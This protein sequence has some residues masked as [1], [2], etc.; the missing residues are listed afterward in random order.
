MRQLLSRPVLTLA[1]GLLALTAAMLPIGWRL[2]QD[3]GLLALFRLRGPIAPP[4]AVAVLR[5]D[6]RTLGRFHDLP[7]AMA[8][9]PEPL[10]GCAVLGSLDRLRQTTTLD[11]IP[12]AAY[13][14]AVTRLT[15]LG[16]AVIGF[17][18]TFRDDP[19]RNAGSEILAQAIARHG[20]TVVLT[21]ARR[22]WLP[23]QA[24]LLQPE[25]YFQALHPEIA[26]AAA[27]IA[28]FQLPL[29][30][31][32]F[33]QFWNVHP[34]APDAVQLPVRMLQLWRGK[35]EPPARPEHHLGFFG[36]AGTIPNLALGD[37]LTG[38]EGGTAPVGGWAGSAVLIGL[39]EPGV[40]LAP[41]SFVTVFG[42]ARGIDLSGVE[43]AATAF[44]NLRDGTE[45]RLPPEGLRLSIILLLACGLTATALRGNIVH[46]TLI[47][48]ALAGSWA[49][50]ALLAFQQAYWWLPTAV[51]LLVGLP[52]ALAAGWLA[53]YR[54]VARWLGV[55]ATGPAAKAIIAGQDELGAAPRQSVTTTMFT[56]I[57]GFS[58]L[59]ETMPPA[60]ISAF[61]NEHFQLLTAVVERHGGTV[62]QFTGDSLMA[63]W[64]EADRKDHAAAGCRA[65]I[66]M[67]A[68]LMADNAGRTL[69]GLAPVRVRLGINTGAAMA[70]NIGAR[71]RGLY[72]LMGDAVNTAQRI[73]Q[74]GKLLCTDHPI[75]AV[76]VGAATQAAAGPGFH[77]QDLGAQPIRGRDEA[78]RLYRLI[79][80]GTV[81]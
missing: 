39:Q 15:E 11:R 43:I 49:V 81:A 14:C 70:G 65:A 69:R 10:R 48:I 30:G 16:V 31:A 44:A 36:P 9:W 41:D 37:L 20:R 56:D 75:A 24:G 53:H 80:P 21:R 67:A 61:V 32:R 35:V 63:Y 27:T 40:A 6:E 62:A 59:S 22:S 3:L 66:A 4:A 18:V 60:G 54:G 47:T 76:L 34:A 79:A 57:V 52:L 50:I 5:I 1:V 68:A 2:E 25:D 33:H 7:E 38:R 28:A 13:G 45:L 51:P 64:S 46:A 78:L 55:Y 12:R 19:E 74:M 23:D 17:D 58:T 73:E 29:T 71:N 72:T 26:R 77:F 8:D 42:D